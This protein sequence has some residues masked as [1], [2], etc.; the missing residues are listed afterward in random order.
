MEKRES[1][2]LTPGMMDEI[3]AHALAGYPE[4]VCGIIAGAHGRGTVLYRGRNT[5]PTPTVAYEMDVDTLARQITFEDEG[6]ALVAIYHSHP[7]GPDTPSPT[8]IERASYPG[9]VYLIVSL[10]APERP[11]VRGFRIAGE[12]AREIEV[13]IDQSDIFLTEGTTRQP[14]NE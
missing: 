3:I 4:E 11:V 1:L 6:L 8:D 5:S 9:S 10:V 13:K 7:Y 12:R 2:I 14:L